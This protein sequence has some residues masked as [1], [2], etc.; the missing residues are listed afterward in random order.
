MRAET[1]AASWVRPRDP[2]Q[3]L[4]LLEVA[5]R[6]I[7]GRA[8]A[9]HG[10]G[11]LQEGGA[12]FVGIGELSSA[13]IPAR[14]ARRGELLGSPP[15]AGEGIWRSHANRF[16]PR[17]VGSRP[18]RLRVVGGDHLNDPI[19]VARPCPF[20]VFGSGEVP[21]PPV[22]LRERV[23]RHL[24]HE[25]LE[26]PVLAVVGRPR[27]VFD[28]QEFLADQGGEQVISRSSGRALN[29]ASAGR[30]NVL[31]STA[32]SCNSARSCAGRPSRRAAINPWS[33]PGTSSSSTANR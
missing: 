7:E 29:A 11:E 12:L 13:E 2:E 1:R 30:G 17:L 5:P 8:D 32:P 24:L 14:G 21:D 27:I 15:C 22:L 4:G 28:R 6:L 23:V 33:E 25:R 19:L 10:A 20:Q 18:I 31:P 9:R 16:R 26:E 3:R